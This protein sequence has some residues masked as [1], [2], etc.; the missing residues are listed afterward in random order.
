MNDATLNNLVAL[1]IDNP[2]PDAEP[3]DAESGKREDWVQY[4]RRQQ[5]SREG[6]GE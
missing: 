2:D 4:A 1:G 6:Q 3:D 5:K